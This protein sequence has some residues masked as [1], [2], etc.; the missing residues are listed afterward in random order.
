MPTDAYYI[1]SVLQ[2]HRVTPGSKIHQRL[3]C[4]ALWSEVEVGPHMCAAV[5]DGHKKGP[6][7][8]W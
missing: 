7:I 8:H 3:V 5:F 1:A 2:A 4:L 6:A